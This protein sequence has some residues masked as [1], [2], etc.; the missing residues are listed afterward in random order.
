MKRFLILFIA[1]VFPQIPH[2]PGGA[3]TSWLSRY[4]LDDSA[5]RSIK[6]P[7]RLAEAS[8]LAITE[9]GKLFCHDDENGVLY[10]VDYHTWKIVKRFSL[11]SFT[12][13]GDF[14]GIAVKGTTFYLVTSSGILYESREGA[15]GEKVKYNVYRTSL[16]KENNV[17][18]LEYDKDSD[19]LLLACKGAAG[20]GLQDC[21]AVYAF[22]LK[23]HKLEPEPRMIIPLH[24]VDSHKGKFHPSGIA[25]HPASG[26]YFLISAEGSVIVETDAAGNVLARADLSRTLNPRPEGIAFAPDYTM[27]LCNDGKMGGQ[28]RLVL[29]RLRK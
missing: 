3:P 15:D 8:G 19:C 10:Q 1:A 16:S 21:R 5:A 25:K 9:D 18:G 2:P 7:A 27:I 22:S 4:D 11:G 14:E 17:E 29:Y 28:G 13:S 24:S 20:K 23:T 6:L 12:L 26:T